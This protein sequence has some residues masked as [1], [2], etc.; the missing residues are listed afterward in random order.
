MTTI[1]Y[2][3]G[4]MACDSQSTTTSE[5]GGSRAFKCVKMY[6]KG[7]SIVGLAGETFAG[8]VFLDWLDSGQDPP[9][10]LIDG[11]ADFTALVLRPGKRLYEYDRWCRAERINQ[12]FYAVGSGAKAALGALHM[13]A[14]ARQAVRIACKI[15]PYSRGPVI[16]MRP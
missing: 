13:G 8:L 16:S 4:E 14:S 7:R 9:D 3:D 1:V 6:R 10:R 12:R 15:D 11:D 5:A 2:R